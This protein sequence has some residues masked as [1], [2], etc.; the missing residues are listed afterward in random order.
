[1]KIGIIGAGKIGTIIAERLARAGH[2][3]RI[4]NSRGPE[5][6]PAEALATGATAVWAS[7][8]TDGADVVII[9]VSLS[10]VPDI[11]PMVAKAPPAAVII[12]TSNY[13]PPRDGDIDA[14]IEGQTVESIWVQEH[15]GR[16]IIKAWNTITDVSFAEKTS[17]PGTTGR[18]A[19][20]VAGDDDAGRALAMGLVESTGFEAID[21]GTLAES[22]R[23]QPGTP[24]YMT[25]LTVDELPSALGKADAGTFCGRCCPNA[26]R[27]R[28]RCLAPNSCLRWPAPSTE[29]AVHA[30]R[31]PGAP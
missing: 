9:S 23:Q 6:V 12:D 26:R 22:W 18:I 21:A 10:R 16:P 29:T 25:D 19:L 8:V 2:E 28:A 11:A 13:F 31:S 3:V 27:P 17:E 7:E 5:T 14:L 30:K 24:V 4:A 1:M 15:Y 20:P